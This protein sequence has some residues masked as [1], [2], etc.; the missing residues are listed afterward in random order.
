MKQLLRVFAINPLNRQQDFEMRTG[1]QVKVDYFLKKTMAM[2]GL[3]GSYSLHCLHTD[4]STIKL[5]TE[6]MLAEYATDS[7][8]LM[9][10]EEKNM[11]KVTSQTK[12]QASCKENGNKNEFKHSDANLVLSQQP[13]C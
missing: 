5:D 2:M 12:P 4:L 10:V 13:I 6:K 11:V 8:Y 7:M 1:A 3:K 9:I